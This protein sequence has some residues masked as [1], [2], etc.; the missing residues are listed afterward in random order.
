MSLKAVLYLEVIAATQITVLMCVYI[1]YDNR[2]YDRRCY[3]SARINLTDLAAK[4][5]GSI[6][7]AIF[8]LG[9]QT[10]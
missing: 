1:L 5:T 4:T 3:G 10:C 7:K 2:A 8:V 9:E 6:R